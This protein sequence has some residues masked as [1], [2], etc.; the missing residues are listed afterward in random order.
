MQPSLIEL[1]SS[2]GTAYQLKLNLDPNWSH[3]WE[4]EDK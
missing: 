4:K 3:Y 2:S 1:I